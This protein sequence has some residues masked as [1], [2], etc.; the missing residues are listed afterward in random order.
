MKKSIIIALSAVLVL[1][2]A[3]YANHFDAVKKIG[4]VTVKTTIENN[5]LIVGDNNVT[6]VLQD[7]NGESRTD[8]AVDIYYFM[9]S[10]PAMNYEVRTRLKGKT[11]AAVIKPTM[12]GTWDADIRVSMNGE[13]AQKVTISFEAK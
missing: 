7:K 3:A 2:V 11:Y 10:M 1:A 4:D 8:A 12:P 13:D 9:P 6:I 5:P